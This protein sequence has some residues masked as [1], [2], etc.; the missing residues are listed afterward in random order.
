MIPSL[1]LMS[2]IE[3][4]P[5]TKFQADIRVSKPL[6][7]SEMLFRALQLAFSPRASVAASPP[8]R[9]A[10]FAKRLLTASLHW[11]PATVLHALDFVTGLVERDSKLE[12]LSSTD[13]RSVNGVYRPD[14]DAPQLSNPFGTCFWELLLLSQE[15]W[16]SSVRVAAKK[17]LDY[18]PAS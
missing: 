17:L 4:P 9:S 18:S 1:S 8:W 12:A 14:L 2:H 5:S 3:T 10:A 6:S 13:D 11:P 15:Y 16:H 7:T